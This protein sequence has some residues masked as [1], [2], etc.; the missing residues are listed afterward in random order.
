VIN[1]LEPASAVA[2]VPGVAVPVVPEPVVVPVPLVPLDVEEL[3]STPRS[4]SAPLLN[5][6]P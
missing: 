4:I 5:T 6:I 1:V 3:E 2:V